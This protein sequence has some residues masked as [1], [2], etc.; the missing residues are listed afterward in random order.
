MPSL[1]HA[2]VIIDRAHRLHKPP[3]L[4][5]KIPRDV[6]AKIH[7]FHIKDQLMR[8]SRQN[9][10]LPDP[11]AGITVYAD[12]FQATMKASN[13][14]IPITKLLRNHK[15]LYR[16]GFPTKFMLEK[17]NEWYTISS[18]EKGLEL[19]RK[20]GLLPHEAYPESSDPT[21]SRSG[22]NSYR[23]TKGYRDG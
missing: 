8:F 13:N 7:F 18:L 14:L 15:I 10:T 2:D 5:E 12:L 3:H 1:T 9:N 4:P 11:Y 16:W 17:D 20:W 19:M 6:I 23:S 22:S 21:T